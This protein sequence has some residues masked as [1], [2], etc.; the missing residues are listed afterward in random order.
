MHIYDNGR[1]KKYLSL[2]GRTLL[3][4]FVRL[5]YYKKWKL[6]KKESQKQKQM[7]KQTTTQLRIIKLLPLH[8]NFCNDI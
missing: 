8:K 5:H 1:N 3:S 2:L 6:R 7:E 4:F